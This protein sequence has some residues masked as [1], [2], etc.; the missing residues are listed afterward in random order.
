MYALFRGKTQLARTYPTEQEVWQAALREGLID[1]VPVADEAGGQVLPAG[2]HIQQVEEN[3]EPQA[4]W[5]LPRDI[6]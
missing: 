2:F 4:D 6:S 5:K 3:Y 1:D